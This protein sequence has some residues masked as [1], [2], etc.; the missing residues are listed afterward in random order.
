M[1][2]HLDSE[3]DKIVVSVASPDSTTTVEITSYSDMFSPGDFDAVV[4]MGHH[5]VYCH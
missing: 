2:Q 4:E 1:F 5:V 3:I